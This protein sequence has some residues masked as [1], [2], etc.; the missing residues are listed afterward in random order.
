MGLVCE[1]IFGRI[2]RSKHFANIAVRV[3]GRRS[4][5]T[6]GRGFLFTGIISPIFHRCCPIK[7]F[8]AVYLYWLAKAG[9]HQWTTMDESC[10]LHKEISI[11]EHGAGLHFSGLSLSKTIQ[12]W[13][14]CYHTATSYL[15][16]NFSIC[17]TAVWHSIDGS[18]DQV[19]YTM[20]VYAECFYPTHGTPF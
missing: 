9:K 6:F 15:G 10:V 14:I 8:Q 20:N 1:L 13:F 18:K 16:Q 5:S 4:L 12:K 11:M 3:T 7:L 19:K 17:K 2:T